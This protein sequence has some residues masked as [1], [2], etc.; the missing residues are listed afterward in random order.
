M[1][2]VDD[3]VVDCHAVRIVALDVAGAGVPD[4]HGAWRRIC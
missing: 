3:D 4:L 2:G 1:V